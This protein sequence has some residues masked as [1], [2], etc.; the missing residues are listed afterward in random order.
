[1]ILTNYSKIKSRIKHHLSD[2]EL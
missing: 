1:M 2:I